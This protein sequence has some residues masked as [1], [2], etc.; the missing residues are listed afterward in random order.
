MQRKKERERKEGVKEGRKVGWFNTE[1]QIKSSKK[2]MK[3]D[4]GSGRKDES[5][6]KDKHT[7]LR[8]ECKSFQ[9]LINPTVKRFL[10]NI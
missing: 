4:Q 9:V 6:R 1:A 7:Q 10:V 3:R 8:P 5:K 2:R